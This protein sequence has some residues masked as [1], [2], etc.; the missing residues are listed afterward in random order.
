MQGQWGSTSLLPS[1]GAVPFG[2]QNMDITQYDSIF[3]VM[4]DVSDGIYYA[5]LCLLQGTCM[6]VV[7]VTPFLFPEILDIFILEVLLG[8]HSKGYKMLFNYPLTRETSVLSFCH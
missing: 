6:F 2:L 7:E 1:R 3:G 4:K 5:G 8:R